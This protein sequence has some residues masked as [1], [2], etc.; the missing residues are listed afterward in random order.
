[1]KYIKKLSTRLFKCESINIYYK[2][3]KI[4]IKEDDNTT[5]LKD[6]AL[7]SDNIKLKI[8]LNSTLNS[9]KNQTPSSSNPQNVKTLDLEGNDI[10]E[11]SNKVLLIRKQS[12]QSN[13][14]FELHNLNLYI[15]KKQKN[16]FLL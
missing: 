10:I 2:G 6:I 4:L 1:M 8:V 5:L 13:K 16:L 9:T 15:I 14:L 12:K 11:R 7:D 3:N